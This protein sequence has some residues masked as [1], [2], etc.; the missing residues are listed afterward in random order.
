[1]PVV[2]LHHAHHVLTYRYRLA[3]GQ[4][5][6]PQTDPLI[7]S[8]YGLRTSLLRRIEDYRFDQRINTKAEVV[9]RALQRGLD[10]LEL[11]AMALPV[12]ADKGPRTDPR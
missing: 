7:R 9:R 12:T 8:T 4:S 6:T 10:Q 5:M 3:Q 11:E 2:L 1:M